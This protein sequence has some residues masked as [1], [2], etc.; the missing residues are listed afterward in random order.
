MKLQL[1]MATALLSMTVAGYA[2]A[3][4]KTAQQQKMTV[5]NQQAGEK[6]LKGGDRKSFMSSCL[7][8][9]SKADGM[10]PQQ[11]KMKTCNSQAGE[12]ML[13]GDARKTFMSSCLKKS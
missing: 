5:C 9:D 13:K 12:K 8:K 3:A 4:E 10:T 7:K 1:L 11:L 2:G 6:S